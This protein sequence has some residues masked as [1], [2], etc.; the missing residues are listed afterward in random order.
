MSE[1]PGPKPGGGRP[2]RWERRS[3]PAPISLEAVWIASFY[4]RLLMRDRKHTDHLDGCASGWLASGM[5]RRDR[6]GGHLFHV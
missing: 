6:S 3:K 1:A 4:E 5:G 2:G